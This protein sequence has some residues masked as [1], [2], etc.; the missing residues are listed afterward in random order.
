[1]VILNVFIAAA[2]CCQ[3][4]SEGIVLMVLLAGT[5]VDS[6]CTECYHVVLIVLKQPW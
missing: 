4:A 2:A 1:M 3:L 5:A 6:L